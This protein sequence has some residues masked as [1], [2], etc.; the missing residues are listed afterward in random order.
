MY[1]IISRDF[2]I[3]DISIN[4]FSTTN[5][6]KDGILSDASNIT[7]SISQS[8]IN[9]VLDVSFVIDF[10][11]LTTIEDIYYLSII[12][13][14][15]NNDAS[16]SIVNTN[17]II[18]TR[19]L[20]LAPS[21][22]SDNGFSFDNNISYTQVYDT[23][24]NPLSLTIIS[25]QQDV[26]Y[27]SF[28]L[29]N[30]DSNVYKVWMSYEL[31]GNSRYD[32]SGNYELNIFSDNDGNSCIRPFIFKNIIDDK[33]VSLKPIIIRGRRSSTTI[34][35]PKVNSFEIY[36]TDLSNVKQS[37]ITSVEYNG[38]NY[39]FEFTSEYT[40]EQ[41]NIAS[42]AT[43]GRLSEATI[44]YIGFD[45]LI[46]ITIEGNE[47][48]TDTKGDI[49]EYPDVDWD[50]YEPEYAE[51]YFQINGGYDI[52]S[53][54]LN[55]VNFIVNDS[56]LYDDVGLIDGFALSAITTYSA[57]I[58]NKYFIDNSNADKGN[59]SIL[60]G[61]N[62]IAKTKFSYSDY[63]GSNSIEFYKPLDEL[64]LGNDPSGNIYKNTLYL[65]N[66]VTQI[67]NG[68]NITND[69][70]IWR[71][72]INATT[73]DNSGNN[74][75]DGSMVDLVITGIKNDISN[76]DITDSNTVTDN[77]WNT[78]K[79]NIMT[80]FG[81]IHA[82]VPDDTINYKSIKLAEDLTKANTL[83]YNVDFFNSVISENDMQTKVNGSIIGTL[84][85]ATKNLNDNDNN[86]SSVNINSDST[87][88]GTYS[89]NA[90]THESVDISCSNTILGS[91]I[92]ISNESF[93]YGT[94]L[95]SPGILTFDIIMETDTN[96][97][98]DE[99]D[100]LGTSSKVIDIY[101]GVVLTNTIVN[102]QTSGI[103]RPS[104]SDS[105][106][107]SLNGISNIDISG[108]V[109]FS[110]FVVN[111]QS[112]SNYNSIRLNIYDL[113]GILLVENQS[114]TEISF[115]FSFSDLSDNF[116]SSFTTNDYINVYERK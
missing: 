74:L 12:T 93:S 4:I 7:I 102:Y 106:N 61:S 6:I 71:H 87:F 21:F 91:I 73:G 3:S 2:S 94:T 45:N 84:I 75:N 1:Q 46:N 81:I 54:G 70:P 39:N 86:P 15:E 103:E 14:A 116:G 29:I 78:F 10:E 23:T 62:D 51:T 63:T 49:N 95:G 114:T 98:R 36:Y 44:K 5:G 59:L 82:I 97:V 41:Q 35:S 67:L 24:N 56:N 88:I 111:T 34:D 68:L 38:N 27:G 110:D 8:L 32:L 50:T 90:Y 101:V 83:K 43:N 40:P 109:Q 85:P 22:D 25:N 20:I 42:T 26:S 66:L 9:N 105:S 96:D 77:S 107:I 69:T 89:F 19:G 60:N 100:Q 48:S 99:L 92:T 72:I 13:N 47:G 104:Y 31:I 113:S 64:V 17:N 108:I 57:Y 76:G 37:D 33:L 79:T 58:H 80:H 18:N 55:K 115:E 53:K 112:P 28:K 52:A 30:F 16:F 11:S 65:I